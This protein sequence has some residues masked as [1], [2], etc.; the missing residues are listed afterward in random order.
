[1]NFYSFAF[2]STALRI[3]TSTCVS[4]LFWFGTAAG[5]IQKMQS[6]FF[7]RGKSIPIAIGTAVEA[8]ASNIKEPAWLRKIMISIFCSINTPSLLLNS[9]E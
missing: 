9:F 4:C 6:I 1:M 7:E 3:L 5:G 2:I 8:N